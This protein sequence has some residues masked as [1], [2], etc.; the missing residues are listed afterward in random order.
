MAYRMKD[1]SKYKT[2]ED[3]T[4][5]HFWFRVSRAMLQLEGSFGKSLFQL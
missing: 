3:A 1:D 2:I 4:A 5:L